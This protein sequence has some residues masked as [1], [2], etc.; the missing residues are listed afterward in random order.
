MAYGEA[1]TK[2]NTMRE[3]QR[4][5]KHSISSDDDRL[6]WTKSSELAE[7]EREYHRL[8]LKKK[9]L[10]NNVR[11]TMLVNQLQYFVQQQAEG[12]YVPLGDLTNEDN[13]FKAIELLKQKKLM[14]TYNVYRL[15]GSAFV[16][17]ENNCVRFC[18][19]T[20][21]K[22]QFFEPFYIDL[23]IQDER[24]KILKHT[25]PFF[26]PLE[27]IHKDL[28]KSSDVKELVVTINVYLKAYISRRQQCEQVKKENEHY[29]VENLFAT[30]A[31]DF[32][33][34]KLKFSNDEN[35]HFVITLQYGDLKRIYHQK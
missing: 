5:R 8:L 12:E 32:V 31:F 1:T 10:S 18:F 13:L 14:E 4:L 25:I 11:E 19:D 21:Y 20:F 30:L 29:S 15:T 9:S 26:I 6:H 23:K 2:G 17:L 22:D 24:T 27:K 33:K 35:L 28:D 16:L 7:L 34:F 3:F